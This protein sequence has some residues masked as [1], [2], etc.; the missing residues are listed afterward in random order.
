MG[1]LKQELRCATLA[2]RDRERISTWV[3][4]RKESKEGMEVLADLRH[5]RDK[6]NEEGTRKNCALVI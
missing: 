4:R 1:K 5:G 6:V 2:D 3:V